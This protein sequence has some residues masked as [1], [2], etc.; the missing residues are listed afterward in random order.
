MSTVMSWLVLFKT[1]FSIESVSGKVSSLSL[2]SN[3]NLE[4]KV[5]F[6]HSILFLTESS[7]WI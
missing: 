4:N 1:S 3:H 7:F 5:A 6:S 2:R